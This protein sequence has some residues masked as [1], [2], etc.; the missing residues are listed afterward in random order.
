M[1]TFT[2]KD[3][4][5]GMPKWLQPT[6]PDA[7]IVFVSLEESKLTANRIKG[8]TSPGWHRVVEK[9]NSDGSLTYKVECLAAFT[10]T[11][12]VSGDVKGDDLVVGDVEIVIGTQPVNTTV[13]TA[14]ATSFTVVG[15]GITTYQWQLQTGGT[16][17]YVNIANAGVYLGALLA[18]LSISDSTGLTSNRYRVVCGNGGTAQVTSRGASLTVTVAA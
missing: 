6:V 17:A 11:D 15:T 16:G 12:A 13:A 8:I 10:V 2:N 5:A 18:T 4:T 9:M 14:T 1:P 7:E 3:T